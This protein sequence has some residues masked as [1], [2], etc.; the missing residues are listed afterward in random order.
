MK[1]YMRV[2]IVLS[3]TALVSVALMAQDGQEKKKEKGKGKT[4]ASTVFQFPKDVTPTDDQKAKLAEIEKEFAAKITAAQKKVD[5]IL[6]DD[7]KKARAEAK[8][9]ANAAGKK[10]KEAQADIEAAMK[11]SNEQKKQLGEAE[12]EL[13]EVQAQ[14]RQRIMGLLTDEQKA[15]LPPP[16]K[17]KKE[18]ES[19]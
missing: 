12:G 7:Q 3:T 8:K 13:R 18:K 4:A 17:P 15:K 6:T 19:K 1:L 2:A 9:A 11:L 16:K 5:S 14:V 10:G